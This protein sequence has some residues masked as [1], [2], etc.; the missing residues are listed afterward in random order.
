MRVD[1]DDRYISEQPSKD[2]TPSLK[3]LNLLQNFPKKKLVIFGSIAIIF[4]L[5]LG[6]TIFY[7]S[8]ENEV[9]ALTPPTVNDVTATE[10]TN[11]L[12]S[13]GQ[14]GAAVNGS[15]TESSDNTDDSLS[16]I[17]NL[18]SEA[19]GHSNTITTQNR[20]TNAGISNNINISQSTNTKKNNNDH[21][22]KT[23]NRKEEKADLG[24]K[25]KISNDHYVIQLSASK[26][27][28]GL[29]K[30]IKQNNITNYHI[31]KTEYSSGTWFILVKG[32]YSS[33][34]EARKA[35]KSLPSALL[36]DKPWVKSGAVVN[37]E[38]I[39]K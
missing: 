10:E 2:S 7:S 32:D 21:D 29:K 31:Y 23:V 19:K 17:D 33:A 28:E 14:S 8:R 30:F 13:N 18:N 20:R 16:S 11:S 4:L 15:Q 39:E 27:V 3:L 35:I 38:K 24:K 5:L 9:T 1:K 37:K 22:K 34:N 36:K 26:S 12:I 25:I 6:L